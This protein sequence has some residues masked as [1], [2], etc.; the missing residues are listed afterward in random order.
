MAQ[1]TRRS[2]MKTNAAIAA[3]ASAASYCTRTGVCDTT[4]KDHLVARTQFGST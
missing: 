3:A 4:R 1:V 2:W